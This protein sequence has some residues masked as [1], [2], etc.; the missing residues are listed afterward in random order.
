[1]LVRTADAQHRP[2][3]GVAAGVQ[4][5]TNRFITHLGVALLGKVGG[6]FAASTTRGGLLDRAWFAHNRLLKRLVNGR[7]GFSVA[8][9]SAVW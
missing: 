9:R 4:M 1:V 7:S 3:H 5:T 6:Q 2:D 8:S